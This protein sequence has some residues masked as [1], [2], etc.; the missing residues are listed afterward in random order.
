MITGVINEYRLTAS[1]DDATRTVVVT[2]SKALQD[3]LANGPV[4]RERLLGQLF[5]IG[6]VALFQNFLIGF[7]T[8]LG[9][10]EQK[11][12]QERKHG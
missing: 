6:L 9:R 3:Q 7:V 10:S 2:S 4:L 8:L 5:L 1:A 11:A 12:A